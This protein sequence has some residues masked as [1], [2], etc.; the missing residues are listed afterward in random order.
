MMSNG[1]RTVLEALQWASSFLKR[2][3]NAPELLL[4]HYLKVERHEFLLR[5]NEPLP[6]RVWY[7]FQHD[8]KRYK[9]EHVPVQYLIGQEQ[10]YGRPFLVNSSVLIPRPE[11]EELV[12]LVLNKIN[13]HFQQAT[14]VHACDVGTG[15]GAIAIT[16]A[17]EAPRLH[18]VA[19]D[20]SEAALAVAKRNA[21]KLSARV[22]FCQGDLLTPLIARGKRVDIVVSNPPYIETETVAELAPNVRDYEPVLALDGGHDGL[23]YYRRIIEGLPAVLAEQALVAFEVGVGQAETVARLLKE[24]LAQAVVTIHTD[25]NQKERIVLA[26]MGF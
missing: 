6:D 9:E 26:E 20:I 10:F 17:L 22:S 2:R 16:L 12:L 11:T 7:C 21:E 5:L 13:E 24:T 1:K 15:S 23:E 14:S 4:M 25:M 19:T 3:D 8:L 18:V